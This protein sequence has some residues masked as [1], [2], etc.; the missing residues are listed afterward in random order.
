M[1]KVGM[2]R[3]RWPA[4]VLLVLAAGLALLGVAG[5]A[6]KATA[7]AATS[8][9]RLSAQGAF[10]EAIDLDGAVARRSGPIFMF[11]R[12]TVAAAP[13][14]AQRVLLAWAAALERQGRIDQAVA[15]AAGVTDPRLL[16]AAAQQRGAILLDAARSAAARGDYAT[17]IA[18]LAQVESGDA[19][20]AQ[21]AAAARLLP[22]YQVGWAAALSAEGDGVDA[23]PLL[24]QVAQEGDGGAALPLYPAALWAAAQQE[25]SLLSYREAVG[26]LDRLV[27]QFPDSS[28]AS[29][30]QSLL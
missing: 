26:T 24:D 25:I 14:A 3:R 12:S 27:A 10:A 2:R 5:G 1:S 22:G 21:M 29:Q 4:L 6:A 8:A 30:A 17:A 20:A 18:R 7:D 11:A 28:Q 13:L 15:V 19:P 23:V 16:A 9:S